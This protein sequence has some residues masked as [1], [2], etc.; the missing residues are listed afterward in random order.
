M[1]IDLSKRYQSMLVLWFALL[2]SIGTNFVV[3]VLVGSNTSNSPVSP[4]PLALTSLGA[5]LV[6]IS[7]VVKKKLLNSSV[8]KQDLD[9]VQ[10][11]MVI[12]CVL[13]EASAMLGLVQ[14][15]I[16]GNRAAYG[17]LALAAAG[18]ALHFPRRLQ[19]EAASY[20]NRDSLT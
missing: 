10:K 19:L 17:L 11:S 16:F 4:L 3:A 14:H 20:K 18:I 6:I 5:F 9:L 1:E 12:A 15:F 7:F 2:M 8:E 13:C